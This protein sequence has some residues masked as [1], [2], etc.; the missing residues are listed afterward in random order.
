MRNKI[1][2]LCTRPLSQ[3]LIGIVEKNGYHVDIIPFIKTEQIVSAELTDRIH[4][5]SLQSITAIITSMNAAEAVIK[6]LNG[7]KPQWTFYCIGNTTRGT[8]VQYFGEEAIVGFAGSASALAN[9]IT[10]AGT[11]RDAVFFCG[12][13]RRDELPDILSHNKIHIEELT[14]YQTIAVNNK[15]DRHYHGILFFSPS[16]VTSFFLNNSTDDQTVLFAIGETTAA[17]IRT[18]S[19]NTIVIGEEAGKESLVNTMIAYFQSLEQQRISTK[20]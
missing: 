20:N 1:P 15:I 3:Q 5:F 4:Q 6:E 14:V 12:D 18:H 10:K 7:V 17:A 9:T 11:I 13:Q 2:I 8:L 16:A 19:D